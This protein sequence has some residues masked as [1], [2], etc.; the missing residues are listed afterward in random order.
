MISEELIRWLIAKELSTPGASQGSQCRKE[1]FAE[2]YLNSMRMSCSELI[3]NVNLERLT[4]QREANFGQT[5]RLLAAN[6]RQSVFYQ[7]DLDKV[8]QDM[9][10]S[11]EPLPAEL[12]D[13]APVM[14]RIHD[15]MFR[16]VYHEKRVIA[17]NP[18]VPD[19]LSVLPAL[20]TSTRYEE[21]SFSLLREAMLEELC[22][23]KLMPAL[24]VQP[25]QILWGRSPVRLDLAGGW[26]DTPPYCIIFGGK[27]VNM[28]VEL[29][30]QPPLQVF[31]RPN[32]SPR[33][34][35]HSIDLGVTETIVDYKDLAVVSTVGSAFSIPKAALKLCGFHPDFSGMNYRNLQEQLSEF[36]GGFDIT[37]MVAVPKGSGLGTSSILAATLLGTLSEFCKLGWDR[38]EV[39]FRTL[40]LEQMLTTG[41]GWQDQFGGIFEG[42]K[43]VESFPGFVQRPAVKWVSESLLTGQAANELILLYYTGINR[44][45]KTILRDIVRGMFLNSAAQLSVL[46]EMKHHAISSCESIQNHQWDELCRAIGY[47]WELN[48]RLD[49]GTN[50]PEIREILAK[51]SDYMVSCKLLGAGGGGYLMIFAKDFKAAALIRTILT[52]SPPNPMARFVDWRLSQTGL[53][54][55]RS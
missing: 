46:A 7:L 1:K 14:T 27:V 23:V 28:A 38:H 30:G 47:S 12:P 37:L 20:R 49:Q 34:V 55:S 44:V 53:A 31:I 6:Y 2:I 35:I 25:D 13:E 40:I 10:A 11:G 15:A 18:A 36:G 42:L 39:A 3:R 8:T 16:A 50:T 19:Q 4:A 52:Q 41:G 26:T 9:I 48:Q 54:V 21:R 43:L 17:G 29:N 51:I 33:I 22:S 45:A 5:L 32:G 24:N